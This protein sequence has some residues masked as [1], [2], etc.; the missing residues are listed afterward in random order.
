MKVTVHVVQ[1]VVEVTTNLGN[2]K[3]NPM[4]LITLYVL[5]AEVLVIFQK[6]VWV[7]KLDLGTKVPK[8][9]WMKSTCL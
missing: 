8:L 5:L 4:L 2:V 1:T 6:I 9:L 7:K 3:I